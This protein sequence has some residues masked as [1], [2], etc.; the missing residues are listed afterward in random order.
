MKKVIK[1][2]SLS[3]QSNL[4]EKV[5]HH[6]KAP[7]RAV[8]MESGGVLNRKTLDAS[9]KADRIIREAEEDANRIRDE[10]S[11]VL[12]EVEVA[13]ETAKKEGFASGRD[14]GMA[15]ATELVTKFESLKQ[16]FYDT[17]EPEI[18]SLVMEIAE[19]VI[20]RM[21]HD[22]HQAI[23]SIVKQAVESAL[24]DRVTIRLN[25]EDYKKVQP[26]IKELQEG[27]DKS[28]RLI[29]KEDDSISAGGCVVETEVGMIDAQ[30]ETQLRAIRKALEI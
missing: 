10:A 2:G 17:A 9:D 8:L 3:A 24:G 7:S 16:E 23:V 20:G 25:P 19:K 15:Q 12:A 5:K 28:R 11:R 21:V 22:H 4:E 27:L 13:R 14:E 30:L 29:F 6:P 18:I 26:Q 1:G